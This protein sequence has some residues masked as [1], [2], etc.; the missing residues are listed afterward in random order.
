[1]LAAKMAA[2]LIMLALMFRQLS[3]N[4]FGSVVQEL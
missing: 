1:M 4:G 2:S 3:C